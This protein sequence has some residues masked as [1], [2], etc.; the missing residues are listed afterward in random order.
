M[1]VF[2]CIISIGLAKT[3]RVRNRSQRR[4]MVAITVYLMNCVGVGYVSNKLR[5]RNE[6]VH[7]GSK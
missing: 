6:R 5:R 2:H 3:G 1:R 7:E 4:E